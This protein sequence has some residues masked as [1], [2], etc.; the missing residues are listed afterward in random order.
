MFERDRFYYQTPVLAT[1]MRVKDRSYKY[2][3]LNFFFPFDIC[4]ISCTGET[5]LKNTQFKR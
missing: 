4:F 5:S 3:L 2:L 1:L